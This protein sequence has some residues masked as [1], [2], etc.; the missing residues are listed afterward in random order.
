MKACLLTWH[1]ESNPKSTMRKIRLSLS[2]LFCLIQLSC[3]TTETYKVIREVTG[4]YQTNCYLIYGTRSGEAALIDPGWRIDTLINFI[5][6]NNLDLKYILITHGHSDHYYYVPQLKKQFPKVRWG[7]NREDFEK[8]ILCPDWP[9]KAYGEEWVEQT[10]KNAEENVYL[11]FDTKSAGE[12]D[13]FVKGGQTYRLGSVKIKTIHTPGHSPGCVCYY[14]GNILFSGD[15][16]FYRSV[17]NLDFLTSN[18]EAFIKS[19]RDLYRLFPDSTIVYPGHNQPTDIGSEKKEN[20]RI[21]LTGGL[22]TWW[23]LQ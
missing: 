21:S 12:P 11:D 9:A 4:P 10:R 13:F 20:Q 3:N 17:G 15:M 8:I 23:H 2:I 19:V 7:V 1:I 22:K 6:N 16:L 14:T 18:T 5:K